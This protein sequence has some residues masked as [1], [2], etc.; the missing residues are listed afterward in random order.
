MK[1]IQT[2]GAPKAIGPY[3]QAIEAGNFIFV[4]GQIPI[5]PATG[6][7]VNGDIKKQLRRVLDNIEAVLMAAGCTLKNIVKVTVFVVDLKSF[8]EINEVYGEY[9]NEHRPARSFVEVSALPKGSQI[10]IEVI[11]VKDVNK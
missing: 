11:A 6:E 3:S 10:E 7:L 8:S 1:I 9:F 2:S 5:D 4:S